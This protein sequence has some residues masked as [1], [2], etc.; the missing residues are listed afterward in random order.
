MNDA[1]RGGEMIMQSEG[2]RTGERYLLQAAGGVERIAEAVAGS[3]L[4]PAGPDT[5]LAGRPLPGGAWRLEPGERV[6]RDWAGRYWSVAARPANGDRPAA[7]PPGAFWL[8]FVRRE[9]GGRVMRYRAASIEHPAVLCDEALA[10]RLRAAWDAL[11]TDAA[12]R[13]RRADEVPPGIEL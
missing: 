9:P 7:L 8:E 13:L 2:F 5:A 11:A 1:L 3:G 6:I 10:R 4:V 12:E